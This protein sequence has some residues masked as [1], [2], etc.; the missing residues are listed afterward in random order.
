VVSKF[1]RALVQPIVDHL[2][3][4]YPDAERLVL[5]SNETSSFPIHACCFLGRAEESKN[6]SSMNMM[7]L[8]SPS[9]TFSSIVLGV[10][11]TKDQQ[12]GLCLV[13][14]DPDESLPSA[15]LEV[16]MVSQFFEKRKQ[17]YSQRGN[18]TIVALKKIRVG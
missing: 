9:C 18:W 17:Y 6:I 12:Y 3:R 13:V 2:H 14:E 16:K 8:Y 4:Y 15:E 10:L 1:S 11:I 7:S 5:I